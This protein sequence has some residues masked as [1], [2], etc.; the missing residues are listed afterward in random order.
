MRN[1]EL[2]FNITR[3]ICKMEMK[4]RYIKMAIFFQG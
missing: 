4:E 3:M 1:N 2:T